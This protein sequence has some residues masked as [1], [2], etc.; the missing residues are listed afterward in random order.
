M[1][2][3]K[4]QEVY[5]DAAAA[6]PLCPEVKQ[7][8]LEL[9]EVYG[10]PGALHSM[11]VQAKAELDRA[12][13][14]AAQ[15]IGAHADEIIFTAS[16]TE[17]NNLALGGVLDAHA[18]EDVEA[19]TLVTEHPSV[20]KTLKKYETAG[21]RVSYVPV[22]LDGQVDLK[23]ITETITDKTVI[24]SVALVNS[25]IGVIQDVRAI[26]KAIRRARSLRSAHGK[27]LYFH[28][29]ASQAPLWIKL[30]VEQL[31]PDLMTLDGQKILGPKGVG[32][33][34]VR[35]GTLLTP[36]TLGGGQEKGLRAGTEN[37][38]LVGA[39]A[40]ALSLAQGECEQNAL[41]V[42]ALRDL[43]LGEIK[44]AIPDVQVNGS[45]EARIANNVNISIPG[46]MGEMA[47]IALSAKGIF[48]ST[49]SACSSED[50]EVSHV[51]EALGKT[52]AQAQSALRFTLLP[53]VTKRDIR[54]VVS[55]LQEVCGRYRN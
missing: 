27:P 16:G 36:Q 21:T 20:L 28:I 48:A 9:L 19:I 5:A 1:G 49:R 17:A 45:C 55:A 7:R 10:N 31:H 26:A 51:L 11:G 53:S 40:R 50:E 3:F 35:R 52:V 43:L 24:V 42:T 30:G 12:R 15:A 33:L 46:L 6:T 32:L 38:P 44:K 54:Q 14:E 23:N 29:D 13:L 25:E 4:K 47:V 2:F 39:M 8:L 22:G 37:I 34:Y 41:R 18:A